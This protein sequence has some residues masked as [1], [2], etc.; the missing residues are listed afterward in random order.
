LNLSFAQEIGEAGVLFH[1][2]ATDAQRA[3][4]FRNSRGEG[5]PNWKSGASG[6]AKIGRSSGRRFSVGNNVEVG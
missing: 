4:Q 6:V 1:G 5:R 2:L 3:G